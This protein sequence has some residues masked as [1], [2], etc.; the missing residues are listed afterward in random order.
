M[1]AAV[2][3]LSA[4]VQELVTELRRESIDG[5]YGPVRHKAALML[6]VLSKRTTTLC[7]FCGDTFGTGPAQDMDDVRHH[8]LQCP[9]HPMQLLRQAYQAECAWR[10]HCEVC[11]WCA[12]TTAENCGHD[13]Q[14]LRDRANT[15]RA[16]A[17]SAF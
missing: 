11:L 4:A 13:A 10:D 1:I 6:E 9:K 14:T 17:M 8:I 2:N 3:T 12:D 15:L 5:A 16:T 7:A